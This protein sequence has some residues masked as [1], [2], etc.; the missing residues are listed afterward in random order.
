MQKLVTINGM[1][2]LWGT[3][4]AKKSVKRSRGEFPNDIKQLLA[5]RVAMRCSNPNCRQQTSGPCEDPNESLNIGVAAHITAA[6][7]GGPR[8]DP[9]MTSE[10]RASQE[11]GIWLCQN[12]AKLVDNDVKRYT[13]E[14][15]HEWKRLSES[16]ALLAIE[17]PRVESNHEDDVRLIQFFAQAFDRPAFQDPFAQEGS[18]EAF[19]R[20]VEDTI[21][22]LNTGCLRSRDGTILGQARGKAFLENVAWRESMDAIV[23]LLR[24]IRSRLDIALVTGQV[25]ISRQGPEREFYCINDRQLAFWMDATRAEV[26]NLFARVCEI[27]G[28][29]PPRF[30]RPISR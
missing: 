16:A 3:G 23:D 18:M 20:A 11:N 2:R 1:G 7:E 27:A 28:V 17:S 14:V 26:L 30:P 5:Q 21:I 15:I 8:Y 6:A 29:L 22:A 10:E 24:A 4:M 12:C 25:Y 13:T 19:D 9:A